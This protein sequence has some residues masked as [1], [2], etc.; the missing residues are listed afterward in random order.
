MAQVETVFCCRKCRRALFRESNIVPEEKHDKLAYSFVEGKAV[1]CTSHFLQ[2]PEAWMNLTE[3]EGKL[4]CP[5]CDARFGSYVWAGEQCSCGFWVVPAI[6]IPKSKVDTR[7][8][9]LEQANLSS[10]PL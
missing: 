1:P 9:N 2:E 10:K 3:A 5:K 7:K 4:L 8:M 6:Q